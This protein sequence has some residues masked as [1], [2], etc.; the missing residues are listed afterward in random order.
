MKCVI[1]VS[2][3]G[4]LEKAK[5]SCLKHT[6]VVILS[7]IDQDLFSN[8]PPSEFTDLVQ[9]TENLA[10]TLED[11]LKSVG[12]TVRVE[13]TWGP[14]REKLKNTM[15]MWDTDEAIVLVSGS[16]VGN[17]LKEKVAGM[18]RVKVV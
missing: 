14:V 12:K 2:G 4:E 6:F 3:G 18:K 9:E 13:S 17:Q 15:K 5:A 11:E 1:L 10:E 16:K 7:V 8:L